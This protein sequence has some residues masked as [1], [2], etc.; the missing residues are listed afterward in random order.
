MIHLEINREIQ[1]LDQL[2]KQ[3]SQISD[4]EM[5]SHWSR[6]LCVL[7]SGLL[8][9]AFRIMLSYYAKKKSDPNISNF[10]SYRIKGLTNLNNQKIESLLS[11][12]NDDWRVRY[13][14]SINDKEKAAIDSIVANRHSIAHGRSVGISYTTINNYYKSIKKA[15][16]KI[17][18]DCLELNNI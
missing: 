6:Y 7:V 13:E 17:Y 5:Q 1:K 8:E 15:L 12:F 11:T 2:F 4:L 14:L 10:V 9:N 3:V 16:D 18:Y